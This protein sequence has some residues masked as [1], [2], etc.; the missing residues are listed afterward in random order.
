MGKHDGTANETCMK[1]EGKEKPRWQME[2]SVGQ[3]T[4]YLGG[5]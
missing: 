2:P 3:G 5:R 4:E 1:D